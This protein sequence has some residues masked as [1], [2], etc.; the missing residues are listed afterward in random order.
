MNNPEPMFGKFSGHRRN[1]CLILVVFGFLAA[2]EN[3]EK[4][5]QRVT[6]RSTDPTEEIKGLQTLYSDSG[7][8]KVKV[9][10]A[11]LDKIP[12]PPPVTE[13]PMGIHIEFFNEQLQVISELT[14]RYAIHYELERVWEARNKVV[15]VNRKGETLKT[16]K[17]IWN[18]KK[19]LLTSDEFVTITTPEE[20]I[21]GEGF[22]AN[23]DF[24]Q[25]R[26]FKVKGIITVRK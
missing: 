18:E 17:L 26:I 21:Y 2:C 25:Y 5:I 9:T 11:E 24:S 13:L 15:V 23:Q 16:E 14:A 19:E 22:E 8:V 20:T 7:R 12:G 3:D 10:A 6:H 1:V 4:E